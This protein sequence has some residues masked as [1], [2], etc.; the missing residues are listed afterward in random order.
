MR[1]TKEELDE[2]KKNKNVERLWSFSRVSTFKT[3][4]YEYLLHYI[5]HIDED[6]HNCIYATTGTCCHDTLDKFYER[7]IKYEDMIDEFKNCWTVNRDIIALKFDRNDESKDISI[8]TKYYDNLVHFFKHHRP[9]KHKVV[10]EPFVDININGNIFIGYIDA[11]YKDDNG[12]YNIIDFKSSSIY[13]GATL[14]SHSCQLILYAIALVQKGIPLEKI[15]C[16]FNFLKYTTIQYEQANGIVK[17]RDVERRKV[18][19]SLQ[20]NLKTWIKK[21]GY[22]DQMDE[23]LKGVIDTNDIECLPQDIQDKYILSD[24]YVYIPLTEKLINIWKEDLTTTI[25]DIELREKDYAETK[26]DKYFWDSEEQIKKESYYHAT[27]SGYSANL[28]K[29]YQEYLD[30]KAEK[31]RN[32]DNMFGGIGSENDN[33]SGDMSWLNEL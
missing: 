4:P 2:L 22:A 7:K 12:Y 11:L 9:I 20:S 3:S 5:K 28:H 33:D 30:K 21:F 13:K 16:C 15:K 25:E 29:P 26:S 17:T 32:K 18:G 6:L 8:G 24:C 27:L 23:M 14:E 19:E 1:K 10:I 31:E